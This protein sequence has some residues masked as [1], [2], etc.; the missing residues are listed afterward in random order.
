MAD[1]AEESSLFSKS[2]YK[3]TRSTELSAQDGHETINSALAVSLFVNFADKTTVIYE[4]KLKEISTFCEIS[5]PITSEMY[6]FC[7]VRVYWMDGV[8]FGTIGT[9]TAQICATF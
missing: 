8:K 2:M 3:T 5:C 1:T 9:R 6:E 4:S 7:I